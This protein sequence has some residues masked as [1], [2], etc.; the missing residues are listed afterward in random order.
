MFEFVEG[1]AEGALMNAP[2]P[3]LS[4]ELP[5]ETRDYLAHRLDGA[6]DLYLLALA[7]GDRPDGSPMFGRMIREARIHFASVIEETRIGGL[8]TGAI[9]QM[10]GKLNHE[11]AD[12]IRPELW[13]RV[14]QLLAERA[15]RKRRA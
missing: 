5:S 1:E 3:H 12:S 7:L 9:A 13:A 10:L 8:D 4:R 6:R 11:L 15:A 2:T 14:E